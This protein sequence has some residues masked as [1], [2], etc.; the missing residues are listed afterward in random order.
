L[1]ATGDSDMRN[2]YDRIHSDQVLRLTP[3]LEKLDIAI[4]R[5]ALGKFDEEI[6]YEWN[7]LWQMSDAEKATIAKTK[8]DTAAVDVTS[9]LVPFEALVK[10]RV[11]QLIE[12][13]TYPGMEAG[14]EEA[15]ANQE[16]LDEEELAGELAAQQQPKQLTGPGAKR[17]MEG[18]TGKEVAKDSV[19]PFAR[20]AA[21]DRLASTLHDLLIPWNELAHPRGG[22]ENP[23]QFTAKGLT[24][25]VSPSVK[26]GL[27]FKGAV[28]ELNSRQQARLRAASS[29]ING[30][31]GI[32]G[33]QEVNIIGAWS[34]GAENSIMS[35]SDADWERTKLAS[36]MKG[37]L[38]DQKAVLVFQQGEL[39]T[40]PS[41]RPRT[42]PR[43]SW[44]T[45]TAARSM[46]WTRR[47]RD[48][49]KTTRSTTSSEK[50]SSSATPT[51]KAEATDS[52]ATAREAYTKKSL[53]NPRFKMLKPSGKTY[54][55]IGS[56]PPTKKATR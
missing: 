35:R 16:S 2:Y 7:P 53:E 27:D 22:L 3:Q 8:A 30:K 42:G 13:G 56:R 46:H 45:S 52:S 19:I 44:S 29:D 54:A 10:G 25:F 48:M 23:G 26:S 39:R 50:P 17:G 49:A 51:M 55:I 43:C 15:L 33:A 28:R 6:F 20:A 9:G 40:I 31:V 11:N 12:D 38:A 18:Q 41:C 14:I 34:D 5:S 1:N 37:H 47:Q 4:Q 32:K 36:V 21:L 24:S